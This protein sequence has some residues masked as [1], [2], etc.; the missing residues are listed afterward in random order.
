MPT[1]PVFVSGLSALAGRYDALL[2]DVWGVVHNGVAAWPAASEALS[3]FRAGGGRVV[4]LTNAPRPAG[5]IHVQ[6]AGL[7]VPRDAYDDIVTSGDVTRD[8][9]ARLAA[10]GRRKVHLVGPDRDLPLV[11]GLPI[12]LAAAEAAEQI[13]CTGLFDDETE[14]PDDYRERLAGYVARGLP[15]VCANPDRVVERGDRLIWCAGALADLYAG[16]G[17]EVHLLGKPHAPIYAAARARIAAVLGRPLDERRVLAV[18]DGL[19]TDVLGGFREGLDVLLVTAGIHAAEFGADPERP[20][21]AKV[22]AVLAEHGITV[23]AALP[24]LVW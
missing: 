22:G 4:L 1:P 5:P 16:M 13:V 19:L 8:V 3:R 23:A 20:D 10:E 6:L 15:F 14:T 11:E 17:G 7:G 2:C 9:I 24:R 18:G 12:E 21:P